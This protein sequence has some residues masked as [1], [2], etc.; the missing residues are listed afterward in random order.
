MAE[1]LP[2]G[3][4]VAMDGGSFLIEPEN[5]L[6]DDFVLSL[7]R[8]RPAR[9]CFVPTASAGS[10]R[11]SVKLYRAFS[12]KATATDLT[13]FDS[14]SL[15]QHPA[16]TTDLASFIANQ[17]VVYVGGGTTANLLEIWR[18]HGLDVV[19]R[20]AIGGYK[21]KTRAIQT[22]PSKRPCANQRT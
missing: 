22:S 20:A 16:N 12:G 18:V 21:P 11:Y 19:P 8:R 2:G 13:L 9:V 7:T 1:S 17:E 4:I 10:A 6:L 5:P 15:A 14:S 3:H